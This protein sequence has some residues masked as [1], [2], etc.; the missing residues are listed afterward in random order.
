MTA[1]H[2]VPGIHTVIGLDAGIANL[3]D[4]DHLIHHLMGSLGLPSGTIACTHLIRTDAHRGTAVS[5]A[6]P[7]T[8]VAEVTWARLAELAGPTVSAVLGEREYGP[9]QAARTAALA[10]TEHARRQ[11]GRAVVYPGADRLTGIVT[12][13]DVLGLTA[14]DR[15]TVVGQPSTDGQGPDPATPVLTRDHVRPEWR[16][17]QLTLALVPAPGGA[18]APFEVPNPTPCCADHA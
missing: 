1:P 9:H 18:L 15:I 6:L 2:D 11:G 10:A 3:R 13:T 16:D 12:V 5:L 8:D 4:A 7:D 14:I 17:G